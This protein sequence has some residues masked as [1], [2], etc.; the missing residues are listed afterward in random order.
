M[1]SPAEEGVAAESAEA[2]VCCA[3]CGIAGVDDIKL[4]ECNYYCDLV[5]YCSDKCREEHREEHEEECKN[6]VKV[7][8]DRK[9]FTQPEGTHLGECPI[10][11]LPLPLDS[12]KY[13]FL[14]CCSKLVCN[15]CIIANMKSIRD[16]CGDWNKA[17]L[18][19]LCRQPALM[20]DEERNWSRSKIMKRAKANDPAAICFQGK[21]RYKRGDYVAAFEYLSKAAELGDIEAHCRLGVQ[22][23]QGGECVEKNEEKAVYHF[24][25][26]AIGGH[27]GARN[28]LALIEARNGNMGRAAKHFIIAANL[29]DENAM[30]GLWRHYSEGNITKED[31]DATLRSHQAALVAMKSEQRD[32]YATEYS[33]ARA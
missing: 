17:R 8:H 23:Y 13:S 31:L 1:S 18:C 2:D 12:E 9:L 27:P 25:K 14:P 6:R 30:K 33:S 19:I 3:N 16:S 28:R 4:E 26:A 24:E 32:L 15:G 20:E 22:Y 29:G 10:C 11:F 5:K 21:I 7:L